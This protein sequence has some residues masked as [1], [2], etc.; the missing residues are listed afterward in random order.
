MFNSLDHLEQLSNVRTKRLSSFERIGGNSDR[1]PIAAGG[2]DARRKSQDGGK[3]WGNER[4][5]EGRL[6]EVKHDG[7]AAQER[8]VYKSF[9]F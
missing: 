3:L 2:R 4:Y 7:A 6:K 9:F 1:I 5:N 8:T